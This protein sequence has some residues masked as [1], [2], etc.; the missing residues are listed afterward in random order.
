MN[1]TCMDETWRFMT[2][3]EFEGEDEKLDFASF[4]SPKP[5]VNSLIRKSNKFCT[6]STDK[7]IA[8]NAFIMPKD[9]ESKFCEKR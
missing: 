2:K 3:I 8:G 1:E 4:L 5:S 9:L 7:H 6:E